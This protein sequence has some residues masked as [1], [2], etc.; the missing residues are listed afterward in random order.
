MKRMISFA[1]TIIIM[2]TFTSIASFSQPSG[3]DKTT[4]GLEYK[5][6]KIGQDTAKPKSGDWISMTMMFTGKLNG[7]DTLLFNSLD[8]MKGNPMQFYLPASP[9]QGDFYECIKMMAA[10]DSGIFLLRADSFYMNTF[11]MKG[12]PSGID[13]NEMLCFHLHLFSFS[14]PENMKK[15]EQELMAKYIEENKV[16]VQPLPSGIYIIENVPGQGAGIDTGGVVKVH[17][18]LSLLNGKQLYSTYQKG[19]PSEFQYGQKFDTPGLQEAVGKLKKGS[20]ARVIVPS[21]MAYAE[22]GRGILVPPYTTLVYELEILD[23]KSKSEYQKEIAL[24]QQQDNLKKDSLKMNEITKLQQYLK[25][26]NVTT[27]ALLSGL[28]YI[29]M[30]KGTGEL[31][32]SGD[33]VTVHYTGSLVDGTVFDSSR[34]RNEPFSFTLGRRQ[35]I[36]G[37]DQGIALMR[38]G[39]KAKF[40][41]PSHL[42]Y[43]EREVQVIPAFSTLIFE[44]ELLN[45][46]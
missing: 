7:K 35:V 13:P 40:I 34:E 38:K 5:L 39:G 1:V 24:K 36:S 17:L 45:I 15:R 4:T 10:Q 9:S 12:V 46:K 27:P 25:D 21:N 18:V 42:A 33:T 26:N 8:Q 37:W 11:K 6:F 23:M 32:K 20:K 41:I 19:K 14:S 22:Q 16:T 44:V 3:F 30:V 29:E 31:A 2:G 43:G 28:Y